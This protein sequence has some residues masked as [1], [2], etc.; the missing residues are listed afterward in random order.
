ICQ[1]IRSYVGMEFDFDLQVILRHD[2]IP[3]CKFPKSDNKHEQSGE[4][5]RPYLGWNTWLCSKPPKRNSEDAV[6]HHDGSP[7]R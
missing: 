3:F 7:T 2:A 5:V 4:E 1:F 6:F